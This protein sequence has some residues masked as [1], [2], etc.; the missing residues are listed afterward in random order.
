[1]G[2]LGYPVPLQ[3]PAKP[4]R[5]INA[6]CSSPINEYKTLTL[7]VPSKVTRFGRCTFFNRSPDRVV[8]RHLHTICRS[9]PS[10]ER[11]NFRADAVG[12][13]RKDAVGDVATDM[14]IDDG[15]TDV[16]IIGSGVGGLCCAALLARYGYRVTVCESHYHAG[17]AAHGFT[18]KGFHF[19]AG[20]SFFAGLSGP[21]GSSSNPLK[22]VLDA[23]GERVDCITYDRWMVYS[24][25]I[26]GNEQD[27]F[28]CV[29]DADAY[30]NAI[31][32]VGGPRA[33][34]EWLQLQQEMAPLGEGAALFPAAALRGDLG[35]V[36]TAGRFGPALL[37]TGLLAGSLTGPFSKI[38]D[39]CVTDPW[40]KSFLDLEC[41]VLSGMLAKDTIAAEMVYMYR[42]R[43]GGH[44]TID[45]PVGGSSAIVDA[46]VRGIK[47]YGG[48]IMLRTHVDQ[49]VM[50]GG[51]AVG[52]RIA[53]ND[54]LSKGKLIRARHAVVSNAS[55][56]DTIS[57][58]PPHV[59]KSSP[60]WMKDAAATPRTGSFMHLHLGI[61]ASGLPEDLDCH[62]LFV[63]SWKDI[64]APQNVCIA[65]IPSVFDPSL[66]PKGHAVVHAYTAGNEP[67]ELWEGIDPTSEEYKALKRERTECLWRALGQVIPDIRSR[68]KVVLEGSPLTHANFLRRYKG[69]YGPAISARTGNFPGPGTPVPG[70]WRCG[71]SCAPGIGVP[72]AAA[73]GMI[74]ANSLV[75]VWSHLKLLDALV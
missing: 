30:A 43:N 53:G 31:L 29:C 51:R 42:E 15:E 14:Q 16:V 41:F 2:V 57:L 34:R 46:L 28:A 75:P 70:F 64:E 71:D 10:T 47:R 67:Y 37:K 33:H 52:V 39:R 58:L 49:V 7:K 68:A 38:V 72:A 63:N 44:S 62:H 26:N 22:Q 69:T 45:Y 5:I 3:R 25:D 36:L 32:K 12:D 60:Q 17:G 74:T 61:D 20:P 18:V 40:L 35:V 73:S 66:A 48:K 59:Q 65:S 54:K 50:E 1:M 23:I 55:V 6:T 56:W 4:M 24:K 11:S 8:G 9:L 19:D 13:A 21:P 27:P